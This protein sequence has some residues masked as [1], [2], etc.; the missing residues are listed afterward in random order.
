M[1]KLFSLFVV[2]IL[3]ST[4]V[5]ADDNDTQEVEDVV[6]ELMEDAVP[7]LI[8]ELDTS[9]EVE[10]VENEAID[11]E[12][13]EE[14]ELMDDSIG[15]QVRVL[16]LRRAALKSVI[17]SE[18]VVK[19]VENSSDAD[20]LIAEL[21]LLKEEAD[22]LDYTSASVV[23]DYV[24]IK[25]DIS[26]V[27]K[28]FRESVRDQLSVEDRE[29]IK[30]EVKEAFDGNV[31]LESLKTEIQNS[32]NALNANRSEKLMER[33]GSSDSDFAERIRSGE[34]TKAEVQEFMK[35]TWSKLSSE[36]KRE[37]KIKVEQ[38]VEE[39]KNERDSEI[40]K[41]KEK[42]V[43]VRKERLEDRRSKLKE[44]SEKLKERAQKL[45][46]VEIK[47]KEDSNRLERIKT[48]IRENRAEEIKKIE[49]RINEERK[50]IE[51]RRKE[52]R[53]GDSK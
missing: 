33:F 25:R 31:E 21:K 40:E 13:E 20:S 50:E 44:V 22:T 19:Y 24:A 15:S 2:L 12:T 18:I 30:T 7:T 37:A 9:L 6:P 36:E 27:V 29:K 3:I 35:L 52:E 43:E 11:D 26:E 1:N 23:E 49:E 38:K 34:L 51:E 17:T 28:D 46:R 16:Q 48:E 5:V 8:S 32:N 45:E 42:H 53:A 41:I 39:R 10:E 14:I 47:L 4:I